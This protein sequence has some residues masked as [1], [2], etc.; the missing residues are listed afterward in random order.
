MGGILRFIF[1]GSEGYDVV[2]ETEGDDT[3]ADFSTFKV[4]RRPGGIVYQYD[5]M[6]TESN[7]LRAP[8]GGTEDQL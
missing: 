1:P 2:Q 6:L 8:W 5:F 3:R 7:K 4:S